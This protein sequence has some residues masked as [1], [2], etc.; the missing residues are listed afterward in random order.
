MSMSPYSPGTWRRRKDVISAGYKVGEILNNG[1]V[2]EDV[3][4]LL[5]MLKNLSAGDLVLAAHKISTVNIY[6]KVNL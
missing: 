5:G 1:E 6:F 4:D 2:V 3:N